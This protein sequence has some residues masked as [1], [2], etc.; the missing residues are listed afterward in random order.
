MLKAEYKDYLRIYINISCICLN[1]TVSHLRL[2][3]HLQGLTPRVN[4]WLWNWALDF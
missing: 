4:L 1:I 3:Q 2:V